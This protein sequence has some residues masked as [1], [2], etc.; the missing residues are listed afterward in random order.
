MI[1]LVPQLLGV[2]PGKAIKLTLDTCRLTQTWDPW[3]SSIVLIFR[4]HFILCDTTHFVCLDGN[5]D[6]HPV[7][8]ILP[9]YLHLLP[10]CQASFWTFNIDT[11]WLTVSSILLSLQHMSVSVIINCCLYHWVPLEWNQIFLWKLSYWDVLR[12]QVLQILL[13]IVYQIIFMLGS[14]I[15][16]PLKKW[17]KLSFCV[18]RWM[19]LC[20]ERPDR[21]MAQS[22]WLPRSWPV[23]VWVSNFTF[24]FVTFD[25][26]ESW[27][28]FFSQRTQPSKH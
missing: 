21:E 4:M 8:F 7:A 1:G 16:Y 23:D 3:S 18:S 9:L 10:I 12:F 25:Y 26:L 2:A 28:I 5:D 19:T 20:E 14:T 22:H 11:Q 27:V 17:Q 13:Y 24:T 6:L 15:L